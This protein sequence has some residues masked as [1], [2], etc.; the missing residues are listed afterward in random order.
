MG[1]GAV[2]SQQQRPITFFSQELSAKAQLKSIYERE[3]MAVVLAIQKW[4]H[5]LLGGIIVRTNQKSLKF[6]LDQRL[7]SAKHQKW[8]TKLLGYDFEIQYRPSLENKVVDALSRLLA[9]AEL[10][11]MMVSKELDFVGLQN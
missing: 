9:T 6:L 3:L 8:V 7:L 5:Y 1:L 2:L 10:S 11:I 4:R